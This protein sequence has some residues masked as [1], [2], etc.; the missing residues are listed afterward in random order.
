V[1]SS[2]SRA[3]LMSIH[4]RYAEAI[5]EGRKH[6]EFRKRGLAADIGTVLVYATAPVG[7][8]VGTFQLSDTMTAS[9]TQLWQQF[10]EVGCIEREAF[11]AYYRGREVGVGLL[12]ASPHKFD[13]PVRLDELAPSPAPPQSFS[14]IPDA[15]LEQALEAG[16]YSLESDWFALVAGLALSTVRWVGDM[17]GRH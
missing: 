1:G 3:A 8:L 12:V 7:R 14:Y 16:D 17:V 11:D 5:L 10:A 15:V 13:S 9:P 4:P 6:V 2:P